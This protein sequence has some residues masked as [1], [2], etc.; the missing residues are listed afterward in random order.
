M[1]ASDYSMLIDGEEVRPEAAIAV[2]NP[3]TGHAF[4][5]APRA[6]RVDLDRAVDA[7][8]RAFAVWRKVSLAQRQRLVRQAADIVQGAADELAHVLT[9]EQ[10]RPFQF[11][12]AEV[13]MGA[14]WMR[15]LAGIELP[16]EITED[17]P[18]R[19]IEVHREPLGVICAIVPWNY[20]VFLAVS[21]IAHALLTGNTIVLKP[22]PFTPLATLRVG[23]L[24]RDL[25]PAGVLN[26]IS[27]GDELGPMMSAHKGFAKISFTGSTATG[28]NIMKAIAPE[29]KRATL[30]L[31]GND[32]AIVMP[33]VDIDVVAP[34]I[35]MSAFFNT[36]QIC[37]ATKRLYIHADIY[38]AMRER[39]HAMAL[40][41]KVAPGTEPD[42]VFGPIQNYPQFQRVKNLLA[43][44]RVNGL[45][46]L[47][48]GPVPEGDG[49]FLPLTLVDNPPE[50]ARVVVE[51]AFGPILPL[52]KFS[53]VDDVIR[54]ANASECGLGGSVWCA[55][56]EQAVAIA[57]QLD[58]GSVWINHALLGS[59][60]TPL[61]GRRKS[62]FGVENGVAGLLGF[63]QTKAI[64]IQKATP[65]A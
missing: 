13:L 28:V 12:Q 1:Q 17:S 7:A 40:T 18:T 51:E 63:T 14:E 11:A 5:R 23:E 45:T 29:L 50:D 64:Y 53:D 22:S 47:Q 55:D 25:F 58:T 59:A 4:T 44:A 39:L 52:L 36:A 42:A 48:G 21:K 56:T 2:I 33:D 37:V 16:L 49:Y 61:E 20:P 34:Q 6:T 35:F 65:P 10:G 43:D 60:S 9:R 46:L 3:A 30:E 62:G 8:Q 31:G 24:L 26:I 27:G 41:M 54:R 32:V 15:E 38:D 57:H 19:R